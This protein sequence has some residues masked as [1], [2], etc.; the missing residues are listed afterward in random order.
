MLAET[1]EE[2]IVEYPIDIV[3]DVL[4]SIFPV[5][6][7]K[8][9]GYNQITHD[10]TVVDSFNR[11]F[12]MKISLKENTP[13]TTIISFLATYPHALLD[14][15]Q[16]GRQAIETVLEELLNQL[17]KQPKTGSYEIENSDIEVVNID[18]FVNTTK[19]RTHTLSILVGYIIS[20]LSI[21]LPLISIINYDP[22]VFRDFIIRN[23]TVL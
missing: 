23:I 2:V 4:I 10:F 6:Y 3:Y 19:N 20:L 14:L 11:G 8:L 12:I 5:K 7:Y 22:D 17:D 15:T 1:N 9:K 16:G 13:N 18:N 21:V